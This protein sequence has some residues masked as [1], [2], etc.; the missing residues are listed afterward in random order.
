MGTQKLGWILVHSEEKFG[1]GQDYDTPMEELAEIYEPGLL[2]HWNHT[3]PFKDGGPF[4]ILFGWKNGVFGA[5]TA[6]TTR[7]IK[8]SKEFNFAF[9]LHAGYQEHRPVPFDKLKLGNRLHHHRSLIRLDAD[10]LAAYKRL[11]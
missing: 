5:C 7:K 6:D 11:K 3:Q 1:D 8:P 10:V 2:W 9:R 4:S